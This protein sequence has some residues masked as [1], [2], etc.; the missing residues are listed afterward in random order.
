MCISCG[1]HEQTPQLCSAEPW[2]IP[3]S[4][5]SATLVRG[6]G[7]KSRKGTQRGEVPDLERKK[8]GCGDRNEVGSKVCLGWARQ[9]RNR[10][11]TELLWE[12]S[13]VGKWGETAGKCKFCKESFLLG[14][15]AGIPKA[16]WKGSI[17]G[18]C[19]F[20]LLFFFPFFLCISLPLVFWALVFSLETSKQPE[21]Q[22][23]VWGSCLWFN[24]FHI[25]IL[26]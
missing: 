17:W 8:A 23:A 2:P 10:A 9:Q 7:C 12:S 14:C 13:M 3:S 22:K 24:A 1:G 19:V 26:S 15:S 20:Y 6:V 16:L 5:Q 21:E 25:L 11:W 18:L 4:L